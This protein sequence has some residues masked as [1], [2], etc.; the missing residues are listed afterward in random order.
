MPSGCML[1]L[2]GAT[3]DAG[4]GRLLDASLLTVAGSVL[5]ASAAEVVSGAAETG[6]AAALA[7]GTLHAAR[8]P[9]TLRLRGC[10]RKQ[11]GQ[12]RNH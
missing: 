11:Q 8:L 10:Q 3:I 4:E 5:T 9:P 2:H 1:H 6:V 12:K 7:K